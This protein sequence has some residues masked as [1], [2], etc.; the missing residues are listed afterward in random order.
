[1]LLADCRL[2]TDRRA[3][4]KGKLCRQ[5]NPCGIRGVPPPRAAA[6]RR[7]RELRQHPPAAAWISEPHPACSILDAVRL[8]MYKGSG[9]PGLGLNPKP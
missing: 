7:P 9:L 2:Y 4:P 8:L 3:G 1:M 6:P 5:E